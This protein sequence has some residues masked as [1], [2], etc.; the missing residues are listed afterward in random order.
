[1]TSRLTA[2]RT[3]VIFPIQISSDIHL[4]HAEKDPQRGVDSFNSFDEQLSIGVKEEVDMVLLCSNF[5]H[6][7]QQNR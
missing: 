7:K 1:M 6:E 3:Q 2:V 4:G 5:F